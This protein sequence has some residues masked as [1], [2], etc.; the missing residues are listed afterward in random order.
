MRLA[1]LLLIAA[2]FQVQAGTYAQRVTLNENN[3]SLT[4]V[5]E[6]LGAQSGYDFVYGHTLLKSAKPITVQIK[7]ELFNNALKKVF[8][9]QNLTYTI[10]NKTV[11][12]FQKESSLLNRISDFFKAISISGKITDE[13]GTPMPGVTVQLKGTSTIAYTNAS[14]NYSITVPNNDSQ[15]VFTFIGFGTQEIRVGDKTTINV[16]M[17]ES[18]NELETVVIA[19][20]VQKKTDITGS[21]TSISGESIKDLPSTVNL[22]QALQGRAAGVM[23]MQESGQPGGA[24]RVRI[25]GASS[26]LG[27]NQPLYI[28][29]GVPVVAEGNIPV[30]GNVINND[31]IRQGLSSPLN[32]INPSD[33]ESMTVLKDASATAIYGSRAANGV[34]IITTKKGSIKKGPTYSFNSTMSIQRAQTQNILNAAQFKEL[35]TEAANNST[36]TAVQVQQIKNGTYFRDADTDWE[37]EV[38]PGNPLSRNLN[39]SAAGAT[40]KANY[41]ASIGTTNQ[42]GTFVN[43]GFKRYNL[44]TNLNFVASRTVTLGTSINLSSSRQVSPDPSL[45]SRIY[46][47]RPDLPVYNP[48]G[49]FTFSEAYARE[50]PVALSKVSNVNTTNQLIASAY[51]EATIA[52]DFKL[53]SVLSINYNHGNLKTF[54]PSQTVNGGWGRATGDGSGFAQQGTNQLVSHLWENTLTYNHLFNELHSLDGVMG[55]SWQ[56]DNTEFMTASGMGFPQDDILN[57]LSSATSNFIIQSGKIQSGLV[58]FFGRINYNYNSKYYLGLSARTD[59]SSKFAVENKWAFFPTASAAWRISEEPFLKDVKFINELK[60]RASTGLTGQQN[61]GPYQWR[62]LFEA[63]QY[64]GNP[65][66]IQTQLG[67]A[68]LKWELTNQTDIGVDFSLFN[69]RLNGTVDYYV[70]NTKDLLYQMALPGNVGFPSAISNL[71]RTQNKGIELSLDGDILRSADFRWNLSINVA[72]NKNKLVSLNSDFLNPTTGNISPPSSGYELRIGEPL[73]LIYGRIAEGII[74]NQAE[75]DALNA[76]SP[77]G[78]YQYTGTRPGDIKFKDINGDGK[79]TSLDQTVL[80]NATP[81]F[82]GGITNTFQYKGLSLTTLFTYSAGNDLRWSTLSTNVNYGSIVAGENKMDIALNRWRP[83]KPSDIPRAVYGDP[84]SNNLISSFYVYD[85]SYLRLKNISLNYILP[86][87]ILKQTGFVKRVELNVSATN[88]LTFTKYPGADP[89]TTN[90][91]NNDLSA[92]MDS[93]RFPIAKVYTL[94]LRVGF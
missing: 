36:S 79:V 83:E 76:G 35:W 40:E 52:K 77:D 25:R 59:G 75:L 88:L 71:G 45:L 28:V 43:S 1:V 34:V 3:S 15:L 27:S 93:S 68:R 39:V 14:G 8:E 12:I 50:N 38:S 4:E 19:Y 11:V 72:H 85:G 41:Y 86:E 6:K 24:T 49:T 31:L 54:Y 46:T 33:I 10:R 64:G 47:F 91:F 56:G 84:N 87:K 92:G 9:G 26:L 82:S 53:R 21:L 29:D 66:V 2:V 18:A 60:I 7:N 78:I 94:G 13:K 23:V 90:L 20:G 51:G 63:D 48:D 22:E 73:G 58:S 30:N 37:K 44:M 55:A 89:E 74:Q 5:L 61:F 69:N 65:A 80:G 81:D 67:N 17:K 62:T 16:T 42:D 57:N 70:K 32:N